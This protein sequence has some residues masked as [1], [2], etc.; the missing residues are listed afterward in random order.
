MNQ[1]LGVVTE[2]S[3]VHAVSL[4]VATTFR[5]KPGIIEVNPDVALLRREPESEELLKHIEKNYG[6]DLKSVITAWIDT[7]RRTASKE[8]DDS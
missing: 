3:E 7:M 8:K 6:E 2:D 4:D 5:D 1:W